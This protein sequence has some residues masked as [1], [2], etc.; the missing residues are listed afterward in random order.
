M[1]E[2]AEGALVIIPS[3]PCIAGAAEGPAII[4]GDSDA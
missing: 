3:W 4:S 1:R 2:R